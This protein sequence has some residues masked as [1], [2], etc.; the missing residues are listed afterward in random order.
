MAEKPLLKEVIR[1]RPL[2]FAALPP[3]RRATPA[4]MEEGLEHLEEGVSSIPKLSVVNIPEIVDEN[5]LGKPFYRSLDPGAFADMVR[6]R[7]GAEVAVNKV[8]VHLQ[9]QGE[10]L[11]WAR[12]ALERQG[13]HNFVLVG[14]SSHTRQYP[15][16]SVVEASGMLSHLFRTLGSEEGLIGSVTI[17]YRPQ[18]AE[19]FFAKTLAGVSF[20]TTQL[21]FETRGIK[22]FL[23]SYDRLCKSFDV[24]P[25]TV[26]LSFALLHD[27][28]DLEFVR[29]LGAEIPDELESEILSNEDKS[30]EISIRTAVC[31][32]KDVQAMTRR[33][34]LEV[35][36]GV[37]VE[38]VS[39]R[40]LNAAVG[41]ARQ[42]SLTMHS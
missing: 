6:A 35:P 4:V 25:A 27:L 38:E 19:R 32:Y 34:N 28:H 11:R 22:D 31:L 42:L 9:S 21:I 12:S 8:V 36:L 10:F 30:N 26:V 17:P 23:V 29:W 3:T 13:I 20:A 41:M 15:G 14:G 18:E 16:P 7:T 1:K 5:H 2:F 24:T 37:N 33:F 40:N 39:R